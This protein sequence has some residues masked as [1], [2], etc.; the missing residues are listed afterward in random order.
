MSLSAESRSSGP[1]AE[2]RR[3]SGTST[4][5]AR[6]ARSTNSAAAAVTPAETGSAPRVRARHSA[7]PALLRT[8]C[9]RLGGE[10]PPVSCATFSM[11]VS[12]AWEL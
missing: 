10:I 7:H 2:R 9:G 6:A 1:V 5:T 4:P 12:S 11:D 3:L 8:A